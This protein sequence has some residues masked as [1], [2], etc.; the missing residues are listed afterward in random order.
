MK[1]AIVT[2]AS[3]G[4]G[5]AIAFALARRGYA[6]AVNYHKHADLAEEVVGHITQEGGKAVAV[7]ADIG[8][9]EACETLV[10][11]TSK[12]LGH[13]LIL[14]NN[15]GYSSH[16]DIESLTPEELYRSFAVNLF[17][18]FYLTRLVVPFM[19]KSR[20]GR[21]VNIS[22]LRAMTGS[23]HGPHYAA[24]KSGI[25]GLTKSLALTLGPFGIT[26]NAVAPGY[27][28]TDMTRKALK[29]KGEK[30][31]SQIPLRREATPEEIAEVVAF[32]T[33]PEA[34]Y[35]TGETINVN[36]GLYVR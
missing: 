22:S 6:V 33:S 28:R 12:T 9:P 3:R 24:A 4:I 17:S 27:T 1:V 7:P 16:Y 5:R 19:K 14:V 20:W 34:S 8:L 29:E 35:I 26:V 32:L 21:I 11:T 10:Q 36:G 2:G 18:A 25:I 31:R 30:I 15:A 13:P 23:A